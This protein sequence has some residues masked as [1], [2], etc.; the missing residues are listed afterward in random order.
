MPVT[1]KLRLD[2]ER[3]VGRLDGMVDDVPE[4]GADGV[5]VDGVPQAGRRSPAS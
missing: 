2:P 4:A 1:K 3:D 5:D